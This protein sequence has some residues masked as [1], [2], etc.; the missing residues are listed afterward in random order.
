MSGDC[1]ITASHLDIENNRAAMSS[2]FDLFCWPD[3]AAPAATRCFNERLPPH[4]SLP[5]NGN[6]PQGRPSP[7][8]RH[9]TSPR[10]RQRG[11][12]T[13]QDASLTLSRGTWRG[14]YSR[15]KEP[16]CRRRRRHATAQDAPLPRQPPALLAQGRKRPYCCI[17]H[18]G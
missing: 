15:H 9:N 14:Y 8:S 4:P 18:H 16:P 17:L 3:D 13:T 6:A 10:R 1:G 5:K 11:H 2:S 7:N 12:A